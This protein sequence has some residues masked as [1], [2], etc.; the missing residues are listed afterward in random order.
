MQVQVAHDDRAALGAMIDTLVQERLVACGQVVGPIES[1]YR[2]EGEVRHEQEWLALL[3]TAATS[4]RRLVA[5]VAELHSYETPQIIVVEIAGG[6]GP[7]LEW[8]AEQ[9]G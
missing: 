3:K 4:A 6:H 2:W 9:V 7:Y 8:V 5:R 1:T